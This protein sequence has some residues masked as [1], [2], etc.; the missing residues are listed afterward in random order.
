MKQAVT[1]MKTTALVLALGLATAGCAT[2]QTM[3]QMQADLQTAKNLA[4]QAQ[5]DAA[6]AN[7]AA[8]DAWRRAGA[9]LSV[10]EAAQQ[11]AEQR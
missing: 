6:E 4:M 10:A 7:S 5:R 3:Q 11:K 9:A 1:G 8:A 2:N